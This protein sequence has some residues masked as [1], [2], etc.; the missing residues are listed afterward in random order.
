VSLSF[1]GYSLANLGYGSNQMFDWFASSRGARLMGDAFAGHHVASLQ[2][3]RDHLRDLAPELERRNVLERQLASGEENFFLP[4]RCAVFAKE[5]RFWVDR[6]Y[7]FPSQGADTRPSPNWRE[8][9][10]CER[11]RLNNR[12]RAAIH[13]LLAFGGRASSIVS[14]SQSK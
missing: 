8:R 14:T 3:F 6:L 12:M 7:G 10:C 4:G 1:A 9:V 13:Y 2:Q 11:C 5:T